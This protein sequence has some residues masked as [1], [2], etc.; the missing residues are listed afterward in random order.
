MSH[1]LFIPSLPA[2]AS[3]TL[4]LLLQTADRALGG[5]AVFQGLGS[6]HSKS[7]RRNARG[8]PQVPSLPPGVHGGDGRGREYYLSAQKQALGAQG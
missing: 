7:G 6:T 1:V 2:S 5:K 3:Q 4:L 8:T